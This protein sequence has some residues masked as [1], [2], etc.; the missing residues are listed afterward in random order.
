MIL[1]GGMVDANGM[2][3]YHPS[4]GYYPSYHQHHSGALTLE[5]LPSFEKLNELYETAT[6]NQ[7]R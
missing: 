1:S 3:I 6:V 2:Y 4:T 5:T 7:L